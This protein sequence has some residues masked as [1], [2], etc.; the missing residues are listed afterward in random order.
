[1]PSPTFSVIIPT[2]NPNPIIFNQVLDG[3]IRQTI[4]KSLWELIIVD[5]ASTNQVLDKIV[6]PVDVK[7]IIIKELRQGLSFARLS[8]FLAAKGEYII[9][10]DDDNVL[11]EDYLENS[12]KIYCKYEFVGAI[13]GKVLPK[14]DIPPPDRV[15]DI[16]RW[17][18]LRDFGNKELISNLSEKPIEYPYYAP[19][20][21]GMVIRKKALD[22]YLNEFCNK[23]KVLITDRIGNKLSS[24]GDNDIIL[25]ILESKYSV[26]YFPQLILTHIIPQKRLTRTYLSQLSYESSRSWVQVLRA[27]SICPWKKVPKFVVPLKKMKSY[28]LCKA[29]KSNLNFYR[30]REMCGLFDE[31]AN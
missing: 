10:V 31:L 20:G 2:F 18:S 21:A 26:G 16:S 4:N 11:D 23:K 30:W 13:G 7:S 24:C 12:L 6:L 3:L 17:L 14:F 15:K 19:I 22:I 29:W 28:L 8:G 27:H 25:Y 1:M 5:N 9:L